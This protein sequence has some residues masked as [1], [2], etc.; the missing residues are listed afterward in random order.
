MRTLSLPLTVLIA[1]ALAGCTL[2]HSLPHPVVPRPDQR[3]WLDEQAVISLVTRYVY[4]CHFDSR[5]ARV[6]RQYASR[7]QQWYGLA[8]SAGQDLDGGLRAVNFIHKIHRDAKGSRGL[9]MQVL[10]LA[11]DPVPAGQDGLALPPA[12]K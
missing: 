5:R 7:L 9:W 11:R 8:S 4:E 10:S 2:L 1:G 6:E 12:A 3:Q